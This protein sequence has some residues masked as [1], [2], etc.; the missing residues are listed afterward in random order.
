MDL[1]RARWEPARKS[2]ALSVFQ[3]TGFAPLERHPDACAEGMGGFA[4]AFRQSPGDLLDLFAEF[5]AKRTLGV[6]H[7]K[8]F[9]ISCSEDVSESRGTLDTI[10]LMIQPSPLGM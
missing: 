7:F 6:R 8:A 4:R 3:R 10:G 9:R 2:V 1:A 5:L